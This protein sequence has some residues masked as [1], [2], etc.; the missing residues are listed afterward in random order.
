MKNLINKSLLFS[1]IRLRKVEE[2]IAK[3][4]VNQQMRCPVHLSIGQEAVAV[5]I[6]QNLKK[7]DHLLSAHRSHYHYLAKG[8]DLTSMIGEL[9]GKEN[10]CAQGKGG[11]MHLIDINAG[12]IAAVPIVGS[13]IPIGVGVAWG[14]KILKSNKVVAIFFGD[15]ATEEGVF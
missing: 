9:H 3:E 6:C 14:N 11:S 7:N 5:G 13:T 15:G 4:Y 12:V 8:G 10:G 2:Y 1:M